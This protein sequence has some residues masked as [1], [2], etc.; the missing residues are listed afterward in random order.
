MANQ[1]AFTQLFGETLVGKAGNLNT[2]EALKDVDAVGVYFSAHW[3]PPCRGFTPVLGKKYKALK[4]AGKKVEIVFVS[5]DRDEAAFKEYYGEMPWLALPFSLRDKKNALSSKFGVRGIPMLVI[6]GA[7]GEV[8]TTEGRAGVS[9][10]SFVEDFPYHPKPLNDLKDCL[11]GINEKRCLVCLLDTAN[12]EERAA[13]TAVMQ[14]VADAEFKKA[15]ANRR[16][17]QRFFVA[18]G[19]PIQQIRSGCKLTATPKGPVMLLLD[20][21]DQGAF[22][23]PEEGKGAGPFNAT[24]VAAFL[25]AVESKSLARKQFKQ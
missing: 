25:S 16:G 4:E 12:A 15:E 13:A 14:K 8:I 17:A 11:S 20:L 22:Y 21:G 23:V 19:G 10:D 1:T 2:T 9:A 3:C 7:D 6:L 24:N 5:S 18:T